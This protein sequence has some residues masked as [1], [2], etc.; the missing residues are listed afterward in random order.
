M[1]PGQRAPHG[2]GMT[3]L[4][5]PTARPTEVDGSTARPGVRRR[6]ALAATGFLT[7]AM[8]T[9][10]T[11]NIA[12]MLLTGVESDHRFHQATGQGLV[13]CAIWLG[14]LVPLVR[15][16]WSGRRPSTAAGSRL[17]AF[18][19]CGAVCSVAA[20]GGGAPFLVGVIAVTG[21]LLWWALPVKPVL[22]SA[23]QIDPVLAP[24]ALL[25]AALFVPYAID[26][27]GL[28]N[29]ATG[30][31]AQNPHFFDMAWM[32]VTLVALAGISAVLPAVR[33]LMWWVAGSTVVVGAAGLAFGEPTG[34]SLLTLGLGLVASGAAA[35]RTRRHHSR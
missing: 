29:A 11:F 31:H 10:F 23:V 12:R 8:P 7:L 5:A 32:V 24:V 33:T 21:A 2:E 27:I 28:Q 34:W 26:Q 1:C 14:A 22:R 6:A 4:P 13:L 19:V 9:V 30:Y 15:A 18:V 16:G 20:P 17:L 35:L 25:T 3:T